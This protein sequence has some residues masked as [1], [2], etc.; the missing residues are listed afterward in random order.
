MVHIMVSIKFHEILDRYH[1]L[2]HGVKRAWSFKQIMFCSV[3]V[4]QEAEKS[5]IFLQ[6]E[7]DTV[8]LSIFFGAFKINKNTFFLDFSIGYLPFLVHD[9]FSWGRT[10]VL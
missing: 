2:T 5:R 1:F 4:E 6:Y 7:S 9:Y 8:F 3:F 10:W